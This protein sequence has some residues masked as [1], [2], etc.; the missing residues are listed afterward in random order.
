MFIDNCNK[1]CVAKS[2]QISNKSMNLHKCIA[3]SSYACINAICSENQNHVIPNM[4][5]TT[6]QLMDIVRWVLYVLLDIGR[7]HWTFEP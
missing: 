2:D 4:P 5:Y 3:L 7:G 6:L 1:D